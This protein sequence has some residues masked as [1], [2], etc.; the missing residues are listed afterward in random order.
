VAKKA[1][2][3]RFKVAVTFTDEELEFLAECVDS[4]VY[5]Q[6]SEAHERNN[7]STTKS[8]PEIRRAERLQDRLLKAAR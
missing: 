2:T 6:L 1:P 8:T 4:H 5:W 7:G 3:W